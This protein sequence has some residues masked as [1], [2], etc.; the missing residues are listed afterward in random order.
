MGFWGVKVELVPG[1]SE[2]QAVMARCR[3]FDKQ[4]THYPANPHRD[5]GQNKTRGYLDFY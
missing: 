3:H 1:S 5:F 2:K 4:M